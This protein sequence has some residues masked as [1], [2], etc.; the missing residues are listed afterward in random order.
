[1]KQ[2]NKWLQKW[3]VNIHS[4]PNSTE[5]IKKFVHERFCIIMWTRHMGRKKSHYVK[6]F[7]PNNCHKEKAYLGAAIKGKAKMLIAQLRTSSH[8]LRCK[9][10]RWKVP[11][12]EWE[13]RT[14]LFCDTGAIETKHYFVMECPT[15]SDIKSGY[16]EMLENNNMSHLFEEKQLD[17][18][19]NLIIKMHQR[20]EELVKRL[21]LN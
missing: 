11:K 5:E 3:D 1:M 10:G 14:C 21:Q 15:Y 4:C 20:R 2:N 9:M 6:E 17:K 13:N 18:T 8:Q 7:N 16:S 12:E 19:A